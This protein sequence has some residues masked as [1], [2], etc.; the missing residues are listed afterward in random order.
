MREQD[1]YL[2]N[3]RSLRREAATSLVAHVGL[4]ALLQADAPGSGCVIAC[5]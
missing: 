3:A 5:A 4:F 1:Y 2:R